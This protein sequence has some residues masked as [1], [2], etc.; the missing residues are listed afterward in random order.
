[1]IFDRKWEDLIKPMTG[2]FPD[3][4]GKIILDIRLFLVLIDH[5]QF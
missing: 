3:G 1:M 5:A 2:Y 4:Q